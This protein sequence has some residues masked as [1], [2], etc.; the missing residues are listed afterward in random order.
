[1]FRNQRIF[2]EGQA[3]IAGGAWVEIGGTEAR[4]AESAIR[5]VVARSDDTEGE[6]VAVPARSWKPIKVSVETKTQLRFS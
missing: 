6:Y 1:M 3:Q 5:L 4:S 2:N